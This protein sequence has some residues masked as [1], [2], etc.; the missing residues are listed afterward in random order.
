[1]SGRSLRWLAGALALVNLGLGLAAAVLVF[2]GRMSEGQFKTAFLLA[3]AAYLVLA[4]V[5]GAGPDRR[6]DSP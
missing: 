6:A 4:A 2:L 3:S 1:M 5:R